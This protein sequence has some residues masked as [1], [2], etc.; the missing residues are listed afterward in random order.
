MSR[1]APSSILHPPSSPSLGVILPAA[2]KSTRFGQSKNKLFEDLQGRPVILHVLQAF[3]SRPDVAVIV[4]PT[5]DQALLEHVLHQASRMADGAPSSILHPPSSIIDPR[6]RFCPGGETRAHSVLNGL[7]A[8]PADVEW[9]A[10]HDAA[11]P[12]VSQVLI[13]RTFAAAQAHGAA[14]PALPVHLTIKQAN[15]PLPAPVIQTIP[16]HTLFALQTPQIMRV[17][18]L[19]RAFD[20]VPLANITDDLELLERAG[21]QVWLVDGDDRNLKITTQQDLLL[22]R[23]LLI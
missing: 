1:A 7:H 12:L 23:S 16:R 13:D 6:I 8:L 10:I 9:V 4:L 18:D 21:Q 19:L 15:G 3:L 20:S 17:R 14:A 11:R 5:S 2:G 22:A